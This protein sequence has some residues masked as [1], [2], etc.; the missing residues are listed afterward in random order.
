MCDT[1]VLAFATYVVSLKSR[2]AYLS[3]YSKFF[4]SSFNFYSNGRGTN[5]QYKQ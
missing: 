5:L 2:K 3:Y 1:Y 4:Y